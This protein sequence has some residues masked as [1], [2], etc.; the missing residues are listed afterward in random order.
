MRNIPANLKAHLDEGV[1]TTCRAWRV[2]RTDGSV[3]G[4]TEHDGDLQF[5]GTVF[6][7]ASGFQASDAEAAVGLA[8]ANGEVAGAFSSDAISDEDLTL[9]R[10]DGA[11][12]EVF[13]VNWADTSQYLLEEVREIGEVTRTA[14]HFQAE[15]RSVAARLDQAQ[16]RVYARRCDT[17]LGSA[18]CG[19]D[20]TSGSYSGGGT[21]LTASTTQASVSG[22]DGF[23]DAFFSFGVLTFL[24]GA[25][26]GMKVDIGTHSF[27][28]NTV[29][30]GFWLP[31]P[32]AP[33]AGD[34]FSIVAGCDKRFATCK[35]KFSNAENFRGFPHMPGS[36]F[37][38]SYASGTSTHDGSA[39]FE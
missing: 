5:D 12:V 15:L 22:L 23:A 34:T 21:F 28:G 30:L 6:A 14:N 39:L 27:D 36:D 26:S 16:G 25:L 10:Y 17:D 32:R 31:L 1:T 20:L 9:G 18:Q 13:V 38:Y 4:F 8:A 24:S 29:K 35:A 33:E 3:L 7:A 37:A 2:T 19:V 11:K